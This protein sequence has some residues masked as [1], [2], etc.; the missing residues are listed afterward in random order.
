V[1]ILVVEDSPTQLEKL[2]FL[3]EEPGFSVV[4][5]TNGKEGL[6]A[7]TANRV[8][9]VISDIVMP[10]MDGYALC[11]ALRA[12]ETLRHVPVILL[13]SLADPRDVI[14]GLESGANNFICKPY[15]DR[16]LLARVQNVLANQE[17]RKAAPSEKGISIFFAGQ[18]FFITADR[19]QILDL[20]LSTYENAVDRNVELIRTRDE[21]RVLNEQL[22]TR[23][24][25]RTAALTAEIAEREQA[26]AR[27]RLLEAELRQA[28]KIEAIG[29]LAGGVA[30]DF[31]N[32]LGVIT[33]Y[34]ELAQR[35]LAPEHPARARVDQMM[36]AAGRAASLTRQ[37]LV[38]SR[39]EV[40]QPKLL[41]LNNIVADTQ[42]MLGR[43]IGEDVELVIRAA[44]GLG[45]VKAD[46]GQLE[47]IIMNLAVNAR[48]A[49]PKGGSLTLETANAELDEDY[50]AAHPP[51]TPGGYVMLAISDTGVGMDQETQLRIFEP[52]F[53]TKPEGE[54][55]GLGLATVYGIV[56]QGGG[57][58]SV[59][60]EP[61]RGTTFKVYL[62]RVAELA[63][64]G[65]AEAV[66]AERPRGSETLLL[67]E[68]T[69]TLQEVI[70]ETLEESGYTVL[71][72]SNGDA[73]MTVARERKG[74]IHLL[75]TDV[76]M[77]KLGGADL[78]RLL[79]ALRPEIRVLFMSGYTKGAISRHGLLGEEVLLLEKPFTGDKLARAVREALDRPRCVAEVS[80]KGRC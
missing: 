49:M 52:F 35:Q 30:H 18:R 71:L 60:S 14:R 62:P 32:I 4:A 16:A 22:E 23:V 1:K 47:Q 36:T 48:D 54:G 39:R 65:P 45:T 40:T 63:E 27:E 53:T 31:N 74:P 13:T 29:R 34:G 72:A 7:A 75:L 25:E 78:A 17:I 57:H 6:A 69:A 79:S 10:E 41:D 21:L 43:L 50:A 70:R 59:Y 68:D 56:T 19:L 77:P 24:A 9:L 11:K 51:T 2:R 80:T 37:L 26:N 5:A 58:I 76:V 8:D 38:F 66:P 12:D 46:P 42:K 64:A 33:G 3:L 73:A 15:E 61:G 44:A 28:Q 55:T 67:V 20:L